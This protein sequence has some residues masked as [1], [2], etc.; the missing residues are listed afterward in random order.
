MIHHGPFKFTEKSITLCTHETLMSFRRVFL[1]P[2]LML[3]GTYREDG[4]LGSSL[5]IH[6]YRQVRLQP[7]KRHFG[8]SAMYLFI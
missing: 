8:T 2:V 4:S 1:E 6:D 3:Y 7:E 5:E